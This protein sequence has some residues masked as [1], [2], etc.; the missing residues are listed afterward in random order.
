MT[1]EDK[2][3]LLI[4]S[5]PSQCR[6]THTTC[7]MSS[8]DISDQCFARVISGLR[9][10][11]LNVSRAACRILPSVLSLFKLHHASNYAEQL[12]DAIAALQPEL[13]TE[14]VTAISSLAKDASNPFVSSFHFQELVRRTVEIMVCNTSY[15]NRLDT[16]ASYEAAT[17]LAAVSKQVDVVYLLARHVGQ[18]SQSTPQTN[19]VSIYLTT[20]TTSEVCAHRKDS[21]PLKGLSETYINRAC[22]IVRTIAWRTEKRYLLSGCPVYCR[23][24]CSPPYHCIQTFIS[25]CRHHNMS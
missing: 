12:V 19:C 15:R 13:A 1:A 7:P 20:Y 24:Q 25:S 6:S 4:P 8:A 3:A 17:A 14:A 23:L 21:P 22:V 18:V 10:P 5:W 9:H 2:V 11:A 16:T